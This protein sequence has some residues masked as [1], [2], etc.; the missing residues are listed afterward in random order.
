MSSSFKKYQV[1]F[2]HILKTKFYLF[3]PSYKHE[4]K[5][6]TLAVDLD[7]IQ[8]IQ[9]GSGS[10]PARS[11]SRIPDPDPSVTALGKCRPEP[12][13]SRVILAI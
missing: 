1:W 4:P 3:L 13:N 11:G 7:P 2:F 6:V 10:D 9:V 8:V 5:G 12:S